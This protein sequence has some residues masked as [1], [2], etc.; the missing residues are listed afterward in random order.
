MIWL[1]YIPPDSKPSNPKDVVG[2]TKV[3][4]SCVPANVE[5]EIGVGMTEGAL[6]YGRHNYRVVGARAST[7]YDAARR[8]LMA[9]WEG[10]DIDKKSGLSHVSKAITS[11]IVLRDAM[12]RDNWNDDRPPKSK[13]GWLD[14]LNKVS[15]DLIARFPEPKAV[16]TDAEMRMR[17]KRSSVE[18]Q[19]PPHGVVLTLWDSPDGNPYTGLQ[20]LKR[21]WIKYN[22]GRIEECAPVLWAYVEACA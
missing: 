22:N 16:Y 14:E 18:E 19:Q 1:I 8:H 9:W 13:P 20:T 12:I 3:A 6:E 10:E 15:A 4:M 17:G 7:Y 11:L 21:E 2:S 5:A